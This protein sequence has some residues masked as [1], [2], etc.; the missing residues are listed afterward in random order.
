MHLPHREHSYDWVD[1][2]A[3]SPD[4]ESAR[5]G[6]AHHDVVVSSTGDVITFHQADPT[7]LIFASDGSCLLYTSPS[8]RD[9]TRSRMPSSA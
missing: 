3:K 6:W 1:G 8:P 2:W 7:V 9:R 5:S 4:S